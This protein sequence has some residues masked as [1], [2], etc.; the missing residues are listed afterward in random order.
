VISAA[1]PHDQ[2]VDLAGRLLT[3]FLM[4]VIVILAVGTVPMSAGAEDRT[5]DTVSTNDTL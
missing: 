5:E 1:R 2:H 4:I 3:A